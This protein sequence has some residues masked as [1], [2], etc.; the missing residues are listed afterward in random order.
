MVRGKNWDSVE[1]M[2]LAQSVVHVSHDARVGSDQKSSKYWGRVHGKFMEMA[3]QAN[4]PNRDLRTQCAAMNRW[5]AMQ[6]EISRFVGYFSQ[7]KNVVKSGQQDEDYVV[8]AM[9]M[10]AS[11]DEKNQ[12]FGHRHVWEYLQKHV[13]KFET[14]ILSSIMPSINSA[15]A[16]RNRTNQ[17]ERIDLM[18]SGDNGSNESSSDVRPPGAKQ[19]KRETAQVADRS[20]FHSAM[21][22]AQLERNNLIEQQNEIAMFAMR[23]DSISRKYFELKRSIAMAKLMKEAQLAGIN[24]SEDAAD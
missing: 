14:I 21:I 20:S 22:R 24:P 7:V 9:Q 16:K 3:K 19:A 6:T 8:S 4:H 18:T 17:E 15:T 10:Y 2:I 5:K 13:P 11:L 23:D 12:Q 1:D